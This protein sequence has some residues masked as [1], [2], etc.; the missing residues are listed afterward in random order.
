MLQL[1]PVSYTF[2]WQTMH[3]LAPKVVAIPIDVASHFV[4]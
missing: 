3:F 2:P 4:I 1:K